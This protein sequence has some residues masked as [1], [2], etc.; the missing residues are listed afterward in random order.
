MPSSFE[1]DRFYGAHTH[2]YEKALSEIKSG[3]KYSHW[4]WF[5]FPQHK[6]LG[7]SHYSKQFGLSS[8]DEAKAFLADPVVGPHLLE[9]TRALLALE[10]TNPD[11]VFGGIDTIKL[12][13]SMTLFLAAA[14]NE[15]VFQR[16]L[17]KFFN[18]Q[19]D[20]RTL[21]LIN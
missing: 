5:I 20:E 7:E 15:P 21:S 4:M 12:K 6:D 2:A 10:T 11:D 13:S 19:A 3:A 16:V 17:D 1:I 18:S 14:P 8:I 9:I